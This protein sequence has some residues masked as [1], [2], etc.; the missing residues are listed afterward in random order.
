MQAIRARQPGYRGWLLID[1][2]DGKRLGI[3]LWDSLAEG[4]A[5]TP[6]RNAEMSA[7]SDAHFRPYL[8]GPGRPIGRG[9]IVGCDVSKM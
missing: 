5:G 1:T 3:Y 7:V 2:G 9:P 6:T 4:E 8:V